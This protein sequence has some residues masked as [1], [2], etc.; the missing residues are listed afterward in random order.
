MALYQISACAGN[1]A[2]HVCT[3]CPDTELGRV[4]SMAFYKKTYEWVDVE[5]PTEWQTAMDNGD[6]IV[7]PETNGSYDGGGTP[8]TAPGYGDTKT[9]LIASTFK[10]SYKDPDYEP[11]Y[12]FYNDKKAANNWIPIFRTE[13]FIHVADA[14]ASFV[15]KDVVEDD[16]ESE[17]I[18]Q[19]DVEWSSR[20]HPSLHAIPEGI[21][22]TCYGDTD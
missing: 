2:P 11:N 1:E 12:D 17:V 10:I 22:D 21:F 9:R 3:G 6:V 4:R 5:D 14:T 8:K 16:V 18:W 7:I 13:N 20:N 15:P 19:V